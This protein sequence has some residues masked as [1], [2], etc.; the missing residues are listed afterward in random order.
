M[1]V[2]GVCIGV[3]ALYVAQDFLKPIALSILL[4]FILAPA[5]QWLE[6]RFRFPRVLSVVT[7]SLL[8][9]TLMLGVGWVVADQVADLAKK[10]PE[11]QG[12]IERKAGSAQKFAGGL[13]DKAMNATRQIRSNLERATPSTTAPAATQATGTT[14]PTTVPIATQPTP[15]TE[16]E[17]FG[18]QATIPV[19][20]PDPNAKP[21]AS[22]L[23]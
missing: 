19:P 14:Q 17:L 21:P 16:V 22:T 12:N 5:S 6:R 7:V 2:I 10:L 11:Y 1:A 4:C 20:D 13:L 23:R 8:A 18:R 9:G 3:A 15:R